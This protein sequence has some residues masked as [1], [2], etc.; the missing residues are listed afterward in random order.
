M[1]RTEYAADMKPAMKPTSEI[2]E[3]TPEIA[4]LW[5]DKNRDNQRN[6]MRS[7]VMHLAKEMIEGRWTVTG[8]PIIFDANDHM[9]DGQHR[10][11]AVVL[12]GV[13]VTMMVTRGVAESAFMA[14]DR[15]RPRTSGN[16][17]A[18]RGIKDCNQVASICNNFWKYRRALKTSGSV[19]SYDRASASELLDVFDANPGGYYAALGPAGAVHRVIGLPPSVGGACHFIASEIPES[20][21]EVALFFE[22][23]VSGSGLMDGSPILYLRN[24]IIRS[25]KSR[26]KIG[27]MHMFALTAKAWNL[28]RKSKSAKLIKYQDGESFPEFI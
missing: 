8:Q 3:I 12:S 22:G 19:N 9:I 5:L 15:G 20:S 24:T 6:V 28:F 27:S 18:I 2:V 21:E 17:F 14:I 7:H 26:L 10:L 1:N 13:S 11:R 25:D 4:A 16:I 23:L